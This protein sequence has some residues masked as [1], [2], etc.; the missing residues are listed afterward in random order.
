[1]K[2]ISLLF[3]LILL[4]LSLNACGKKAVD[5]PV[6]TEMTNPPPYTTVIDGKKY[7][8]Q[9]LGSQDNNYQIG[10]FNDKNQ[11]ERFEYYKDGKMSYYYI[12]SDFDEN[13]NDNVQKYYNSDDKLL[14]TF[15]RGKF[16]NASEKE[17][18]ESE[19][20]ALIPS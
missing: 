18:S 1:M 5:P 11:A 2:K 14:A 16:Y 15:D 9:K 17:I 8:A 20:D 4:L 19:M 7:T 3:I 12:S 10:Y 13:G 6:S